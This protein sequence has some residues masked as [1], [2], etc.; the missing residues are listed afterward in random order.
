M[1][2]A[3]HRDNDSPFERFA[4]ATAM[5]RSAGGEWAGRIHDGWDIVGNA[6]GGYLLSLLARAL[7]DESGRP[8]VVSMTAHYLSPGRPGP[9]LAR[10]RVLKSGKSFTTVTG[11]MYA[12][13][14]LLLHATGAFGDL[15]ETS[16][17]VERVNAGP[18]ELPAPEHCVRAVPGEKPFP[19]PVMH[20][21]E[22]R[23]HPDDVGFLRGE[24]H[25]EALVRGWFRLLDDEPMDSI[26]LLLAIDAFPPTAFNA[27]LPVSWTP[28][29][30]LTTH[31]RARP[32]TTWLRC[33][34]TTRFVS[35]GFLEEDGVAWDDNGWM[36]AQSRQLA[37]VPRG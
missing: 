32:R 20:N 30:E 16:G 1:R 11:E 28:T 33:E 3:E 23:L 34:F 7:R 37:L 2:P 19:P 9:V 27:A 24:P 29:V 26:A 8:D 5:S 13:D 12:G 17:S 36:V 31:V 15:D 21:Y 18:P 22:L 6:N 10:P 4:A 25:G 35:N 14:R